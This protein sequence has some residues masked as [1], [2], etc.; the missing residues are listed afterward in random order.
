MG[1][2][3]AQTIATSLVV[4]VCF[5]VL[6]W[7][8]GR[9]LGGTAGQVALYT[10][11]GLILLLLGMFALTGLNLAADSA[12][13]KPWGFWAVW[14]VVVRGFLIV[15]PFTLLA[16]LAELAY[17]WQAA[18]AF[19]QASL[20]TSGAAAG[21]ELMRRAAP[22]TRYVVVSMIVAFVFCMA[23]TGFTYVFMRVAA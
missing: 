13:F 16:L 10:V 6:A 14:G 11:M 22:R 1:Q 17:H 20:M 2:R 19:I 4:V 18:P 3:R 23:W 15:V 9:Y 5:A 12:V 21:A 8:S 7:L